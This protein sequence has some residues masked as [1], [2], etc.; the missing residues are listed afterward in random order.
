MII[1][2]NRVC[3]TCEYGCKHINNMPCDF[4]KRECSPKL[5]DSNIPISCRDCKWIETARCKECPNNTQVEDTNPYKRQ[6]G[7][8]HYKKK[9][10]LFQFL[11]ENE[12]PF[13][14]GAAIKYVYRHKDKG[15]V[16]DLKKAIHCIQMIAYSVYGEV[17]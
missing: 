10:D 14:E 11:E 15:K 9:H 12:V 17:I 1:D 4:Y 6:V 5:K 7:G 2:K 16:E 3:T 8:S 13:G